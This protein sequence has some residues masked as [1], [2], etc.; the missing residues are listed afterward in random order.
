MFDWWTVYPYILLAGGI[1]VGLLILGGITWLVVYLVRR[2][3]FRLTSEHLEFIV[4]VSIAFGLGL[5]AII[6]P[7]PTL[8]NINTWI[9]VY[10]LILTATIPAVAF[11]LQYAARRTEVEHYHFIISGLYRQTRARA[12]VLEQLGVL[13][14]FLVFHLIVPD[15]W[16]TTCIQLLSLWALVLSIRL[17][18][19][20]FQALKETPD[21]IETSLDAYREILHNHFNRLGI[22]S[23]PQRTPNE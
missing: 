16:S 5:F 15:R 20:T 6:V 9:Q 10:L 3:G 22:G 12:I 21:I 4:G 23:P 11:I 13:F 17:F 7:I 2:T 19:R 18:W 14:V 8:F 1:L